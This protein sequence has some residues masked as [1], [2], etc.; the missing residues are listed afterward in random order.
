M[1]LGN[2]IG[3]GPMGF[4]GSSMVV[5]C[6]IEIGYTHT[7]GMP[8]SVYTPFACRR[9]GQRHAFMQTVRSNTAPIPNGSRLTCGGRLSNGRAKQKP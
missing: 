1:E 6:H 4:I 7:G 2:N 5:D 9:G 3:M 8:M